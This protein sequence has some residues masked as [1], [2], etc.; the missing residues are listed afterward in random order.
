M[1]VPPPGSVT[2]MC[3]RMAI[4]VTLSMN[5]GWKSSFEPA[6]GYRSGDSGSPGG[7]KAIPA[8]KSQLGQD[9]QPVISVSDTRV[10]LP[11]ERLIRPSIHPFTTKPQGA[12]HIFTSSDAVR[13]MR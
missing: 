7:R 8:V 9:A 3:A 11:A 5:P 10:R 13:R 12:V 1:E 2:E 4:R 6:T